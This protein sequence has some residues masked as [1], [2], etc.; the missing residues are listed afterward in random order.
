MRAEEKARELYHKPYPEKSDDYVPNMFAM[1][2]RKDFIAGANWQASQHEWVKCS[3]RLPTETDADENGN[4]EVLTWKER[5]NKYCHYEIKWDVP[6]HRQTFQ[7]FR[8]PLSKDFP[9]PPAETSSDYCV[10]CKDME[11]CAENRICIESNCNWP[12]PPKTEI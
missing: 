4:I 5:Y 6:P 12:S 8:K 1:Q 9:E 11:Y 10:L 2:S 7:Y 3:E